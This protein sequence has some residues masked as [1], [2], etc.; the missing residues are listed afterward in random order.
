MRLCCQS[1]L[2]HP[3][4]VVDYSVNLHFWIPRESNHVG[5]DIK[6]NLEL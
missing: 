6:G 4:V 5:G 2:W 1:D 3:D